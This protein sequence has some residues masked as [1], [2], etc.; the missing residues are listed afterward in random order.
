[1]KY[2]VKESKWLRGSHDSC[3][4]NSEGKMCCLGF[5]GIQ[6]GATKKDILEFTSPQTVVPIFNAWPD[7]LLTDLK[8]SKD[9]R[10][11]MSINDNENL[12]DDERKI[13]IKEI[14]EKNGDEIVFEE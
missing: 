6:S 14:F 11:L 4:L 9:C 5:V 2:V 1:M 13:I 7:W 10:N 3:L 12:L 8:N